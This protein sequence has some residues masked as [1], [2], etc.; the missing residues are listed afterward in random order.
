MMMMM[1]MMMVWLSQNWQCFDDDDDDDEFCN[2]ETDATYDEIKPKII[3]MSYIVDADSAAD[4]CRPF[5]S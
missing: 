1:M 3:M 5:M 2:P 4:F